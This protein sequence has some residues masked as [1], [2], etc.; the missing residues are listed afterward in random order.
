MSNA[1][2]SRAGGVIDSLAYTSIGTSIMAWLNDYSGAFVALSAIA[3]ILLAVY[4]MWILWKDRRDSHKK[5]KDI[6]RHLNL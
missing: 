5:I 3:G 1:D 6:E 4:K 2:T